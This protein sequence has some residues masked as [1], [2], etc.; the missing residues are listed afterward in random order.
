MRLDSFVYAAG[1]LHFIFHKATRY[2]Y[3]LIDHA[4]LYEH[5]HT[6]RVLRAVY[7]VYAYAVCSNRT[8]P[9]SGGSAEL[10]GLRTR[11]Y[12]YLNLR[13]RRGSLRVRPCVAFTLRAYVARA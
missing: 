2:R 10:S 6:Q 3:A 12:L 9:N 7:A 8:R 11:A 13:I 1:L 4:D 5:I